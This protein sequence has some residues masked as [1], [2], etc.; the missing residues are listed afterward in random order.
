[1]CLT[2][3]TFKWVRPVFALVSERAELC[4]SKVLP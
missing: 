4:R 2:P 3:A 1:L